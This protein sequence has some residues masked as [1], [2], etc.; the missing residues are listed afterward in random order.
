MKKTIFLAITVL[1]ALLAASCQ[2][3]D[4]GRVL[5]A[6]IEQYEHN[7]DSKA[8]IND[9]NYACWEAGDKVK[10]NNVQCTIRFENG[11]QGAANSAIIDGA[12]LPTDQDLL[13]FYP[14]DQVTSWNGD[15][16]TITLPQIQNYE[17][18][19]GHQIINNPMAAYCPADSNKLKFRNLCALLKVTIQAPN[20]EDL[21]VKTILVKGD[22]D[23]MLWGTAPLT[24][25]Y[26]QKPMLE[27]L[28]N[29]GATVGLNFETPAEISTGSSR[30]F[31]IVVPAGASFLNFT[32]IVTT[33]HGGY[34]KESKVNQTLPR[35]H[36]G[37][38][39]YTPADADNVHSILYEGSVGDVSQKDFGDAQVIFNEGGVLL[40]DRPLTTIG[41]NA[42]KD[43]TNLHNITLPAWVTSIG[44]HAFENCTSLSRIDL[45]E[46]LTS[47]GTHAFD[48]CFS[49]NSIDLPA[50]VTSIGDQAFYCCFSLNSIDLPAGVTSIGDYAFA[51]CT[52]LNSIDLPESL[53]SIGAHAFEHCTSLS[54]ITLP[55]GVTSIG[56]GA[57]INCTSLGSITLPAGLTSIGDNAFE[58]CSSLSSITLPESLTSIG[59]RAFSHCTLLT[60]VYVK[61][62]EQ[63]SN[64]AITQGNSTMFLSCNPSLQI[65]VPSAAVDTYKA[66]DGWKNYSNKIQSNAK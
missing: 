37:A 58:V 41:D 21:A 5:T 65:Y 30:S 23:Q 64:P 24:L 39:A 14:A 19:N 10:I 17:E 26:Q 2:K 20:N 43:C 4:L 9:D 59:N 16:V 63:G 28:T 44:V 13:A 49:L 54:R 51:G 42:F 7:A 46:S 3:E 18:H 62:W 36:I 60:T 27:K 52:S 38:L 61:R 31:Y 50:G 34:W 55:A 15:N 6:T 29:G 8:Y 22:D 12:T 66:A 57:F 45:P 56:D 35:N 33:N 40:F 11:T 47:I 53:T 25:D 48:C 32:F 1:A